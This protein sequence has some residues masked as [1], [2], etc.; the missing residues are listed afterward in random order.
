M[1]VSISLSA[2]PQ[3]LERISKLEDGLRLFGK[4]WPQNF[5]K[6]SLNE[7]PKTFSLSLHS[8]YVHKFSASWIAGTGF[9]TLH[10]PDTNIGL[11]LLLLAC[12]TQSIPD[13]VYDRSFV[14]PAIWLRIVRPTCDGRPFASSPFRRLTSRGIFFFC[15]FTVWWTNWRFILLDA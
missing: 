1:P 11:I 12:A 10:H 14:K 2:S 4:N 15:G 3:T 8:M 9:S 13:D 6:S 5:L 7:M